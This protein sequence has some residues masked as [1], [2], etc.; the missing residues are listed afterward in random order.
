LV[1]CVVSIAMPVERVVA[2]DVP[3]NTSP[4]GLE[5]STAEPSQRFVQH[6]YRDLLGRDPSDDE[7]EA[8]IAQYQERQAS[9][10]LAQSL[11]RTPEYETLLVLR[12]YGDRL[13]RTPTVDE[14]TFWLGPRQGIGVDERTILWNVL[15]TDEYFLYAGGTFASFVTRVYQDLLDR[16]PDDAEL[17]RAIAAL[18]DG[19]LLRANLPLQL[20]T[21]PEYTT[22]LINGY[23]QR[24]LGRP[25]NENEL[26]SYTSRLQTGVAFELVMA[27]ILGS[28]EYL[29]RP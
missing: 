27:S 23:A 29:A 13:G 1:V 14:L 22:A 28:P 17:T 3:A 9:V 15:S 2:Q 11:I 26:L 20:L 12:V 7:L 24:F 25:A 18:S 16:A 8:R 10:D 21:S 5:A 6:L 4:P 19:S